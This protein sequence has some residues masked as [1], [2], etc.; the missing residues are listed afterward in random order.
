MRVGEVEVDS[1]VK[2]L[3]PSSG[4]EVVVSLLRGPSFS[5]EKNRRKREQE[6]DESEVCSGLTFQELVLSR[7]VDEER[8]VVLEE[9]GDILRVDLLRGERKTG[10]MSLHEGD[11]DDGVPGREFKVRF[12]NARWAE[13]DGEGGRTDQQR[14]FPEARE[15]SPTRGRGKARG[16]PENQKRMERQ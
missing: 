14:M 1:M 9:I 12:C 6:D 4:R 10:S 15:C 5:E 13:N 8:R 16:F 3:L 11:S 2:E 7:H